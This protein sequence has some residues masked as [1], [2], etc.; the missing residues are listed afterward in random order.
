MRR[1]RR[2]RWWWYRCAPAHRIRYMINCEWMNKTFTFIRR[3]SHRHTTKNGTLIYIF[4]AE[5]LC[6]VLRASC[7]SAAHFEFIIIYHHF[8]VACLFAFASFSCGFSL[9]RGK[10]FFS[11]FVSVLL[12]RPATA[13]RRR[14]RRIWQ[15]TY[16]SESPIRYG[17]CVWA[18]GCLSRSESREVT[19][20]PV[21]SYVKI[22]IN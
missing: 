7:P 13:N 10:F 12:E 21:N 22:E 20:R 19:I 3:T 6:S 4:W 16:K 9:S 18:T 15:N 17:H 2:Q 1:R 11:L 5:K 8:G 14:K